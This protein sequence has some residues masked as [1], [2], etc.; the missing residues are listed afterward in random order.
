MD[1]NVYFRFFNDRRAPSREFRPDGNC[2][3]LPYH[4][5]KR[6]R[7]WSTLKHQKN[8]FNA[9]YRT[10]PNIKDNDYILCPLYGT[11][12]SFSDFQLGV[13]ETRKEG[14]NIFDC[15]KRSLGEE[16]GLRF[17]GRELPSTCSRIISFDKEFTVCSLDISDRRVKAIDKPLG[18]SD[19]KDDKSLPKA[20][21][22]VYGT[23]RNIYDFLNRDVII[24][25]YTK[26]SD[27][28][29]GIVGVKFRDAKF[30]FMSGDKKRMTHY[31]TVKSRMSS[32]KSKSKSK[33]RR[34]KSRKR[35]RRKSN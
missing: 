2:F 18:E 34:R 3:D 29:V 25:D 6:L 11:D 22:I 27:N 12:K 28:I 32:T 23:E 1:S 19:V 7:L 20:G 16:L 9:V 13:T 14:E 5:V 17:S 26:H 15:F 10:N 4:M 21:C 30:Y 31:L 24:Q 33:S 35:S 8:I